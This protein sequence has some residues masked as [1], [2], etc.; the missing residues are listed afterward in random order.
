MN[1]VFA[2]G[3]NGSM[4][5]SQGAG[6]WIVAQSQLAKTK[7][8]PECADLMKKLNIT[9]VEWRDAIAKMTFKDGTTS[10]SEMASLFSGGAI[11][12][13]RD[14]G[15]SYGTQTISGYLNRE[16]SLDRPAAAVAQ[17]GGH[18]VFLDFRHIDPS[19]IFRNEAN[20]M[21]EALHNALGLT[22][23][24]LQLRVL[25]KIGGPSSNISS[26]ILKKCL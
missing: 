19:A 13:I 9:E 22:D 2:P 7:F 8:K 17:L 10:S 14:A 6:A 12:V 23:A 5:F 20:L 26:E 16:Q 11:Q 25:G 21:H 4:N 18:D 24:F 15:A 3:N 1:A